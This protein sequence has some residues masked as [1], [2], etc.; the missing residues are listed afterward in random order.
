MGLLSL[1]IS[2]PAIIKKCI[3]QK[4]HLLSLQFDRIARQYCFDCDPDTDTD[5]DPD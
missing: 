1:R 2:P 5:I 3:D 4:L